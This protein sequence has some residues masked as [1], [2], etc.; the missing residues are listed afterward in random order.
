MRRALLPF[1]LL[2]V[3]CGGSEETTVWG[4]LLD[5]APSVDV[6]IPD[7]GIVPSCAL[8]AGAVAIDAGTVDAAAY[9]TFG[10]TDEYTPPIAPTS[11]SFGGIVV[12]E[13]APPFSP[14]GCAPSVSASC[15]MTSNSCATSTNLGPVLGAGVVT[16]RGPQIGSTNIVPDQG[17]Y[18]YQ[19]ASGGDGGSRG[20]FQGGDTLCVSAAGGEVTFPS[21][22][23]VAPGEPVFTGPAWAAANLDMNNPIAAGD[24][25]ALTWQPE[26][27]GERVI[28]TV[29]AAPGTLPA[30][31]SLNCNFDASQGGGTL[32]HEGLA[33]FSG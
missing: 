13:E 2:L 24:D 21:L 4:L 18:G 12:S 25:V 16:I 20:L 27:D 1:A 23:V 29:L 22:P 3:A 32:P 7:A 15:W 26:A 33:A 14:G 8:G 5:A 17:A 10:F 31:S 19:T 6:M 30:G 11:G 9:G 28:V